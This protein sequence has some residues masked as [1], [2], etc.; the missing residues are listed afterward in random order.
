[1]I[2]FTSDLHFGHKNILEYENRNIKMDVKTIEEHDN[3]LIYSWNSIVKNNDLV[4][5]LG[6]LSF[7]NA[8]TTNNIV[9]RL[10]GSK[11]LILR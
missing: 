2:Y 11:V 9:K 4:F 3:K 8:E 1:M 10:N 5:I 7:Y 6:D